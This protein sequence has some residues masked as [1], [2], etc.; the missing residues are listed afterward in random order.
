M[1]RSKKD[2]HRAFLLSSIERIQTEHDRSLLSLSSALIVASFAFISAHKTESL[3]CP[4]PLYIAWMAWAAC[5]ISVIIS[6][7]KSVESHEL[8]VDQRDRRTLIR[9]QRIDLI[10][11][12][13]DCLNRVG[14]YCFI[15]GILSFII[16][17]YLNIS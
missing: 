2:D 4:F 16:F 7:R 5:I 6:F 1:T 12:Q 9:Q 17:A 11:S 13:I 8:A 14:V 10:N 15:F 3:R